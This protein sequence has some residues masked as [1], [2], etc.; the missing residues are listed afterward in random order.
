ML[1]SSSMQKAG[2]YWGWSLWEDQ[3]TE[4]IYTWLFPNCESLIRI[5]SHN[6]ILVPTVFENYVTDCRVDGRSVQLALWD[7]AGQEDYERLR[8]LAY[9]KAHVILIG[10]AVDTPDSL[11]N[12]KHKWIEEANERCPGVPIILVGLKKDLREDPLAI[13]EMRKKSLR[14][15][16]SREGS[17]TATQIGARKYLECSSLTGEGVDDVFEAA[18]R[19]AL[20]TFD[21][22]KS[23]CCIVL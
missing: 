10:F 21:K 17:E 19:A 11:E 14:F 6:L 12:V 5:L 22:R 13:E 20:L 1:I 9:S 16:T 18:T 2:H 8:P 7:T 23:S 15:V 4:C 3:F